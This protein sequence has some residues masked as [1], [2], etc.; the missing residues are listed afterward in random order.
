ML[1]LLTFT[2]LVRLYTPCINSNLAAGVLDQLF[3]AFP[4]SAKELPKDEGLF[5][6]PRPAVFGGITDRSLVELVHKQEGIVILTM[7]EKKC[8]ELEELLAGEEKYDLLTI[9]DCKGLEFDTVLLVDFFKDLSLENQKSWKKLLLEDDKSGIKESTPELEGHLKQLYTAITRCCKRMMF[10]ETGRSV[11]F[12]AFL[13]W[14]KIRRTEELRLV[15]EQKVAKV[16]QIVLTRDEWNKKGMD[17][18]FLDVFFVLVVCVAC[19]F[20]IGIS[21]LH[22]YIFLRFFCRCGLG[23]LCGGEPG[24]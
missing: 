12:D 14:A 3:A 24:H 1:H 19:M 5:L 8:E 17:S 20:A 16:D 18:T 13:K 7:N 21:P 10:A 23:V 22:H 9:R 6:G 15:D 4:G 11:A 2:Y